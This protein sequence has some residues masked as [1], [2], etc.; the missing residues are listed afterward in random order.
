[1][2]PVYWLT[3]PTRPAATRVNSNLME[4]EYQ[5]LRLFNNFQY[6]LDVGSTWLVFC[7]GIDLV[8]IINLFSEDLGE[9]RRREHC[10][11][12][13]H[14]EQPRIYLP[15]F[16][17]SPRPSKLAPSGQ[18]LA[19]QIYLV[20]PLTILRR[21]THIYPLTMFLVSKTHSIISHSHV[22]AAH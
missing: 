8:E 17:L 1:M 7:W 22:P 13:V 3:L 12:L 9:R 5:H 14:N 16:F 21:R 4:L 20:V 6:A 15:T 19:Y 11:N 18:A 10:C 2:K